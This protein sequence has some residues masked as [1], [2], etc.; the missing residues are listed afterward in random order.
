ME[1]PTKQLRRR[2]N[3]TCSYNTKHWSKPEEQ[4]RKL[5]VRSRPGAVVYP[6]NV[7]KHNCDRRLVTETCDYAASHRMFGKERR[8]EGYVTKKPLQ[9]KRVAITVGSQALLPQNITKANARGRL[10]NE[11]WAQ[12]QTHCAH[13]SFRT[14]GATASTEPKSADS[15]GT[16][17]TS[18]PTPAKAN[19]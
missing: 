15:A 16:A 13:Q 17:I 8:S 14:H 4:Y 12:R 18:T 10:A 1:V 11:R 7:W 3:E 6:R 9:V 19:E 5:P 2:G